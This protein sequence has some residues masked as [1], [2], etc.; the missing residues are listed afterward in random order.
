MFSVDHLPTQTDLTGWQSFEAFRHCWHNEG[1]HSASHGSAML[2]LDYSSSDEDDEDKTVAEAPTVAAEAP[3]RGG[4][5]GDGAEK[6]GVK[7]APGRTGAGVPR[8]SNPRPSTSLPSASDLLGATGS[9]GV[10]SMTQHYSMPGPPGG[11]AQIGA[12]VTG[13]KRRA[14]GGQARIGAAVTGVKRRAPGGQFP[15]PSVPQKSGRAGQ[16]R[17]VSG[18]PVN[19]LLPP[20]LRGRANNATQDLEALGFKPKH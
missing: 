16:Q 12:A 17:N 9:G 18:K 15:L 4:E 8:A 3:K 10:G 14:P 7:G 19:T 2:G 1:S 13:V 6:A 20:Q 5:A 11:Q